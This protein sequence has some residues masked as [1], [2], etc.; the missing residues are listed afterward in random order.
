MNTITQNQILNHHITF[1]EAKKKVSEMTL[2]NNFLFDSSMENEEDAKIVAGRILK[3]IFNREFKNIHV[4]SQKQFNAIDTIYHSIR[5]DVYITENMEDET[6]NAIIYN[7]EMEDRL[8]DK[9]SLPRRNR[10]YGALHDSKLLESGAGYDELPDFISITISS[11]D[12]FDAED[13]CYVA[14]SLLISHP[15]TEYDDGLTHIYLYC[16]GS[17]NTDVLAPFIKNHPHGNNLREMLHYIQT[18]EKPE[19]QNPDINDVDSVVTKIKKRKEVT[20]KY[21]RQWEREQAIAKEAKID[22]ALEMIRNGREDGV[23]D[24]KTRSRIKRIG[25]ND[26]TI[27]KLFE[28]IDAEETETIEV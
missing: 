19:G 24:E 10:F 9:S 16:R 26:S 7:I 1:D 21:M 6:Y 5:L 17:Q 28:Q 20:T 14:K 2:I 4:F 13:M 22:A 3:S 12:P 15:E 8:A 27:D 23:S 11:Y 25:L 18:G